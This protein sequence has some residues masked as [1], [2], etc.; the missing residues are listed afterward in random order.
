M[1][2]KISITPQGI[3]GRIKDIKEEWKEKERKDNYRNFI[4][5]KYKKKRKIR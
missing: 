3:I 5:N 2:N 1:N 4:N